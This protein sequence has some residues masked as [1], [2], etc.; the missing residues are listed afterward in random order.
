VILR[1]AGVV[2]ALLAAWTGT[3]WAQGRPSDQDIFGGT[4]PPPA[5]PAPS[6][7]AAPTAP[8]SP[9]APATPGPNTPSSPAPPAA[10]AEQGGNE[11]DKSVLGEGEA[12]QHLS[13]YQAPENPLQIGGQIYLRAQSSAFQGGHPLFG[14]PQWALS[15]PSLLD[16]YL[17]A[18]PNPRVR[19]FVLGR[20]SYDPTRPVD[21]NTMPLGT[22]GG[23]G[24]FVG[25]S[26]T[27]FTTFSTGRGPNSLL[28]QMWIRFDVL[29]TV[30]VTAGKQHVRWGTGRF[31]QPTDYLHSLKRNPLDVFDARGGTSMVKL[32]VPW[33]SKGWNFYGV[34]VTE[35]PTD[36]TASLTQVAGGGRAELVILGAEVGVDA[37]F[38]RYQ[39]PRVGIDLSTGI[40][41]FDVYADVALRAGEDFNV[42]YKLPPDQVPT[43]QPTITDPNNPPPPIPQTTA[44]ATYGVTQLSGIKT[45]AVFGANYSRKY[46]DN[47]MWTV[48]AEYF[49]NQPGY[50]DAS[51]YPGL[52][53]NNT[54]VPQLN[55]FYTGRHY[56]AL[57]ASFPA[58]YSWNYTTFTL[59][60]IGNRSDR[61][62]V[63]RLDYSL[64][65]LTHLTLEAFTAVHFGYRAGE[66]RLG[67]DF[68]E[69]TGVPPGTNPMM[70]PPPPCFTF[71]A[72]SYDP[73]L[74]DFGVALRL[75]I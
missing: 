22:S 16:V 34:A 44:A 37:L 66:F 69:Q 15:A 35:D 71:P 70:T 36:A 43:C 7:P 9:A 62:F 11:R 56:A 50:T 45:Q 75:K 60:T 30:F 5:A 32:H 3:G 53:S 52:L 28:D 24:A 61:S 38:K 59:S 54:G 29:E 46:N 73:L 74:F 67:A 12:I 10:A 65:V 33:E 41:D 64:T 26:A 1:H 2:A 6:A 8:G 57:F 47:D 27:G 23:Q 20:M 18:R 25:T 49:Y 68:S 55:F 19:A 40:G 21:A 63:S 72:A 17:D 51:L 31:W 14:S 13:D 39:K 48:G 58:P 42:V 4:A